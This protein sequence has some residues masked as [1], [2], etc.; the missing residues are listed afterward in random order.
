MST[1]DILNKI[2]NLPV[3][4]SDIPEVPPPELIGFCIRC[5]RGLRQWKRSTLA[6]F[7]CVSVSTIERV[8][9]GEKISDE[10]LDRIAQGLGYEPGYFTA[11]RCRL[12]PEQAAASFVETFGE[13]ET[14]A[15]APMNKHRQVREVEPATY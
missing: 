10:P 12:G 14:V 5:A 15:V 3:G 6:D 8:E 9:R 1:K 11:P 7:A 13:M 4:P 2:A